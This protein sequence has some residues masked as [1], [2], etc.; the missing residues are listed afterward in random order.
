LSSY[1]T[2]SDAIAGYTPG[3]SGGDSPATPVT[4]TTPSANDKLP[5][6]YTSELVVRDGSGGGNAVSDALSKL[7]IDTGAPATGEA[8]ATAGGD[9]GT[10]P[11]SVT[12][13]KNN[14]GAA[15]PAQLPEGHKLAD[16][17]FTYHTA[18]RPNPDVAV[19]KEG[20]SKIMIAIQAADAEGLHVVSWAI[21]DVVKDGD[22]VVIVRIVKR[23]EGFRG[24]YAAS[25]D[26]LTTIHARAREEGESLLHLTTSFLSR[27]NK[28]HVN[29]YVKYRVGEHREKIRAVLDA[30]RPSKLC[31]GNGRKRVAT[32]WFHGDVTELVPPHLSNEIELLTCPDNNPSPSGSGTATPA[33][34]GTPG[35]RVAGMPGAGQAGYGV[36]G[37]VVR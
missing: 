20:T 27:Y 23:P 36:P 28:H 25:S 5:F 14:T 29:V 9:G 24:N 11:G 6:T 4:P 10:V 15:M 32:R 12:D 17:A 13:V 30:E 7:R 35:P 2:S 8:G 26:L 31:V 16:F 37:G 18:P 21:K 1:F 19:P 33:P 3:G 22:T 34:L